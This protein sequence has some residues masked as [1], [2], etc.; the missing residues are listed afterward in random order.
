VLFARN[1]AFRSIPMRASSLPL[2]EHVALAEAGPESGEVTLTCGFDRVYRIKFAHW[3]CFRRGGRH[4]REGLCS[5]FIRRAP[6]RS[7]AS[8][9]LSSYQAAHPR[10]ARRPTLMDG[11]LLLL[12]PPARVAP[13]L[14]ASLEAQSRLFARLLAV[15][16]RSPSAGLLPATGALRVWRFV[17]ARGSIMVATRHS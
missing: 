15:S 10:L 2:A 13:P 11:L 14:V 9:N 7:F 12:D 8:G 6:G 4:H 17:T 5:F 3:R 1:A 16:C